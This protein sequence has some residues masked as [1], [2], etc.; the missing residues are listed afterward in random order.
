MTQET[1]NYIIGKSHELMEAVTC[2]KEAKAA[3]ESWLAAAGTEREAEETE[4]YIAELEE[5]IVTVDALIALAESE[6]G[7]KIFGD[8]AKGV[9]D[10]G[11]EIKAAGAKYC[12]C[13]ACAAVEA[14]L[15]K[16]DEMLHS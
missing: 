5:D 3:A 9:A 13:P 11:R 1:R 4:K 10:H 12:D 16:K 14:I 2:S 15:A 8:G 7:A 6:T